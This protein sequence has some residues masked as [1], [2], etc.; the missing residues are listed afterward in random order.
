MTRPKPSKKK[1]SG[2]R[3]QA[4]AAKSTETELDDVGSTEGDDDLLD[5]AM[6]DDDIDSIDDPD[7]WEDGHAPEEEDDEERFHRHRRIRDDELRWEEEA[8]F[9]W[10][11]MESYRREYN[12]R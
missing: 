6:S 3:R 9:D 11:E 8:I 2:K 5:L 12:D 10:R 1:P 7:S 4:V